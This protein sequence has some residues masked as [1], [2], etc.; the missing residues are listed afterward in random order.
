[1]IPLISKG[2]AEGDGGTQD[3]NYILGI[4]LAGSG[5]LAADFEDSV[6]GT[7]HPVIGNTI[8]TKS[9]W[10]HAAATYDGSCWQLYLD[11]VPDTDGLNCPIVEPQH[12][13]VQH[14]GLATA[15][16]SDGTP[17]GFFE[18]IIDEA[19]IWN[20]ARTVTEIQ[21]AKNIEV[22]SATGLIGRWGMNEGGGTLVMD[23]SQ[24][25]LGAATFT[26]EAWVKR[27]SGGTSMGTGAG[28]L[29]VGG[30]PAAYPVI[31]KGM[32][33]GE[34][35]ST[36]NLNM[37]YWFGIAT[38]GVIAAD[39]E[40]TTNGGNHPALGTTTIPEGEWHHIAA[41]YNG[42]CWQLYLD[43][44]PDTDGTN[45]PNLMPELRSIQHTALGSSLL[46]SGLPSTS[47]YFSGTIDE[48]RV[49]SVARDQTAIQAD[50]F[51]ELT[52]GSGLLGRWGLNEGSGT[53]ALNSISGS[54][55]GTLISDPSWV[56][57]FPLLDSEP[58]AAL[59][60]LSATP[61]TGV[62]NLTW[63]APIDPDLAGYNVYRSESPSVSLSGPLNGGSLVHGTSYSDLGV[64]NGT[65]Y[66][67]VVTAKDL[68]TNESLASNEVE[69]TP[70][71]SLGTAL[72]FDGVNDYVTFGPASGLGVT[73]FTLETWVRRA[74][75]GQLMTTGSSGLDGTAGRPM[76]YPV[77]TKGMGEND[78][79]ANL[80]TNFFL[81][82]TDTGVVGADFEDNATGG[83]HP[84][85]GSTLVAIGEWHHIAATYNGSCWAIY[86]DGVGET[87]NGTPCPN[88]TPESGSIQ[89]AALAAGLSSTGA[90]STGYFAG[91][92]DEARIWNFARTQ[93]DIQSTFG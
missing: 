61:F 13:S 41:T 20:Y 40:D 10:H 5:K 75:G 58:P 32:G 39:F 66:Y 73:T 92:I 16:L 3:M 26:L 84:I 49:W 44:N 89:H 8:I 91:D 81:G 87:L 25:N 59:T 56:D 1:V 53:G 88:A 60:D 22:S 67:Y 86:L 23:S 93:A 6:D 50:M 33:E 82:I 83:N 27:G 90:P 72:M 71:E 30:T 15:M 74:S 70:M 17:A 38:T 68:S 65:T 19:R 37:N 85:W 64:T 12:D 2:R 35:L 69:A 80:N 11:G 62:V 43:G 36:P 29:G 55:Y 31:T 79:P 54:P 57:G 77:L 28:G 4:Q 34:S 51:E 18:G 9:L 24:P 21:N 46:S 78:S 48:A 63:T 47:G 45:C 76:A 7:N 42:S 52:S 14:A